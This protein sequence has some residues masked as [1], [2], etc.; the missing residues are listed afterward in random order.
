MT[1][2][3]PGHRQP[4]TV[5]WTAARLASR[6]RGDGGGGGQNVGRR[7]AAWRTRR[8]QAERF[9]KAARPPGPR[10][11]SKSAAAPA[12]ARGLAAIRFISGTSALSA[13][14]VLGQTRARRAT[15]S[16]IP[17]RRS[18]RFSV[19][20]WNCERRRSASAQHASPGAHAPGSMPARRSTWRRTPSGKVCARKSAG[21]GKFIFLRK[22]RARSSFLSRAK[23]YLRAASR[24]V[25]PASATADAGGWGR[26]P[27]DFKRLREDRRKQ[28]PRAEGGAE[29]VRLERHVAEEDV[30]RPVAARRYALAVA[31]D[32]GF[33]APHAAGCAELGPEDGPERRAAAVREVDKR[34]RREHRRVRDHC[35]MARLPLTKQ[36]M[37]IWGQPYN[38]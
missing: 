20:K 25:A 21:P 19:T 14:A 18:S 34:D 10:A 28:R 27:R 12:P 4:W 16:R 9:S 26:A 11:A 37:R 5:G 13:A 8:A 6:P 22:I 31:V 7:R 2:I 15:S 23:K 30:V 17:P 32:L 3:P 38:C 29:A 35:E 1:V 24:R 33:P 36:R